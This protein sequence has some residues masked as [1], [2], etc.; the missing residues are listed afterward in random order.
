MF[1]RSR[2]IT[3]CWDCRKATADSPNSIALVIA[4]SLGEN[5]NKCSVCFHLQKFERIREVT[6]DKGLRFLKDAINRKDSNEMRGFLL[7]FKYRFEDPFEDKEKLEA[8]MRYYIKPSRMEPDLRATSFGLALDNALT[9]IMT[10]LY[11]R[12][13]SEVKLFFP[14][15]SDSSGIFSGTVLFDRK[16]CKGSLENSWESCIEKAT[17]EVEKAHRAMMVHRKELSSESP[18][19]ENVIHDFAKAKDLYEEW[20]R[21]ILHQTTL[22]E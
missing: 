14:D 11:G 22:K 20:V 13:D 7:S 15:Q 16:P 18:C 21:A 10:R 8:E 3:L 17:E 4:Q 6:P 19:L 12:H 5:P 1:F 9:V 2:Q